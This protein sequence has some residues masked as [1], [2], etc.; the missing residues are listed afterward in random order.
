M[1]KLAHPFISVFRF[2]VVLKHIENGDITVYYEVGRKGEQTGA[3]V[4]PRF[5]FIEPEDN[6]QEQNAFD[7]LTERRHCL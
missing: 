4:S 1:I 5:R 7:W 2:G 3:D 6:S